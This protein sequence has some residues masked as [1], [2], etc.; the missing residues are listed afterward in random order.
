M[1]EINFV[2][3]TNPAPE[4]AAA[5]EKWENDPS[6]APLIRP[7]PNEEALHRKKT[8]TEEELTK[9][10][11]HHHIYLIYFNGQLIGEMDYQI[12]PGHLYKKEPGTAWIGILI[13]EETG[14]SKGIGFQAM[15]YL[16]EQIKQHGSKRIELAVFEFNP[17][18][19]KLYQKLGYKE[20]GRI[21]DFTFW[22]GKMW[23]D[24]R[25]EKYL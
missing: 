25:M 7:N 12:D 17:I 15:Q 9:R 6:L 19:I 22:Q 16:E 18:A 23:Q 1:E 8:I 11:K 3:L 2:K 21:N 5:F 14:R 24:I 4:I 20:I 13:G 10:L